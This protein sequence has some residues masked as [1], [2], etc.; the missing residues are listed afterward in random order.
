MINIKQENK[1]INKIIK[2]C[3]DNSTNK[4]IIKN[5]KQTIIFN[6]QLIHNTESTQN[7]RDPFFDTLYNGFERGEIDLDGVV[8][9]CVLYF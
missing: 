8:A 7:S 3:Q 1:F 5:L 4:R 6:K 9:G 2:H